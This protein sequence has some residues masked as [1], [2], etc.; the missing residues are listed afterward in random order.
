MT[1]PDK[2]KPLRE[3][4]EAAKKAAAAAPAV[5]RKAIVTFVDIL[6]FKEIVKTRSAAEIH[7]IL[8]ELADWSGGDMDHLDN[9]EDVSLPVGI[10]GAVAFSDN[11]VR[12][13]P[14]DSDEVGH[15]AF[16]HELLSLV[17]VQAKLTEHGIFLRGGLTVDDIYMSAGMVFGPGLVRAHE[18]ESS[19]AIY[20]RIVVDPA[21]IHAFFESPAMRGHDDLEDDL[22]YI[23]DLVRQG[24]DGFYFVDYLKACRSELKNPAA[25]FPMKLREHARFVTEAAANFGELTSAKQKYLWLARYH[26]TVVSE[27]ADAGEECRIDEAALQFPALASPKAT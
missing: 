25:G 18:L 10:A 15:G 11:V 24:E 26:N 9:D 13:C 12:V 17:H 19:L 23:D 8:S 5:Y 16:F 7:E 21:A 4:L 20:P 27:T 2:Q 22:E 1:K 6:G 14:I 3:R